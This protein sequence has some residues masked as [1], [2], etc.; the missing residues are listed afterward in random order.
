MRKWC[1]LEE[2][3]GRFCPLLPLADTYVNLFSDTTEYYDPRDVK[4]MFIKNPPVFG[5]QY[6]H[7][8]HYPDDSRRSN[9]LYWSTEA[10]KALIK[11]RGDREP[12]FEQGGASKSLLWVEIV[13]KMQSMGYNYSAEKISKKW[14]NI[15]ITYNKNVQKKNQTGYVNWEF[16]D[17]IDVYFK[18]KREQSSD[19]GETS[20]G[21]ATDNAVAATQILKRKSSQDEISFYPIK[22]FHLNGDP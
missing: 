22:R 3:A 5:Q 11:I 1:N 15:M 2:I 6:L 7:D 4:P 9:Q 17:E 10:T 18:H 20:Y 13:K 21:Y 16:F 12:E 8:D 19:D 14:H